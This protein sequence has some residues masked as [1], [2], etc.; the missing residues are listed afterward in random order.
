LRQQD[1]PCDGNT[2]SVPPLAISNEPVQASEDTV[3]TGMA[4]ASLGEILEQE[5][6]SDE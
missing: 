4:H 2:P 6:Y 5:F 1:V 3:D